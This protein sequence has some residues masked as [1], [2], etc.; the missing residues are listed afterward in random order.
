MQAAARRLGQ[1]L[2][3]RDRVLQ[4]PKALGII[5]HGLDSWACVDEMGA[6]LRR[7]VVSEPGDDAEW[8][9]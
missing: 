4:C 8:I 7:D 1:A 9:P 3:Q 2:A 6:R 5:G